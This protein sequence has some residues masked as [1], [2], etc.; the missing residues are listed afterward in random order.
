[1]DLHIGNKK[2]FFK[3]NSDRIFKVRNPF[4]KYNI[5][6]SLI[7]PKKNFTVINIIISLII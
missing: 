2:G 3:S 4:D 5:F 1:M 6:S 7:L